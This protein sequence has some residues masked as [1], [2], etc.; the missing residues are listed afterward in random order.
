MILPCHFTS[1]GLC[2]NWICDRCQQLTAQVVK[3]L[4]FSPSIKILASDIVHRITSGGQHEYNGVHLRFETDALSAWA[5]EDY[6]QQ[7]NPGTALLSAPACQSSLNLAHS[8]FT[9]AILL[10]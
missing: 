5:W 3:G 4:I 8:H 7:V 10:V 1:M 9:A 2:L 6:A